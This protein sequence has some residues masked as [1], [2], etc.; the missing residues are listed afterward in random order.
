MRWYPKGSG[1][2]LSLVVLVS[3]GAFGIAQVD[4]AK[5]ASFREG[6]RCALNPNTPVTQTSYDCRKFR[7]A[8]HEGKGRVA[9]P[10]GRD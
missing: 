7:N 2:G 8:Q 4:Q 1:A 10:A 9:D 5:R 3:L 6:F